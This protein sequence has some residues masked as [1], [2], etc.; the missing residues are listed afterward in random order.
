MV[1]P[2]SVED[3]RRKPRITTEGTGAGSVMG[4]LRTDKPEPPSSTHPTWKRTAESGS[5]ADSDVTETKETEGTDNNGREDRASSKRA[6][7]SQ[8]ARNYIFEYRMKTM[9]ERGV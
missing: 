6:S 3:E 2:N 4:T 8:K 1:L 7:E 5:K 9:E